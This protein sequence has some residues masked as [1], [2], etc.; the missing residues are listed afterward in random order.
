MHDSIQHSVTIRAGLSLALGFAFGAM[1]RQECQ[2]DEAAREK[3]SPDEAPDQGVAILTVRN[4]AQNQNRQAIRDDH[5]HVLETFEMHILIWLK[6][7][8]C[9]LRSHRLL[10]LPGDRVL[11]DGK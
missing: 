8:A 4:Q 1:P 2:I 11:L 10:L 5:K 6:E 3:Q 7:L 9:S